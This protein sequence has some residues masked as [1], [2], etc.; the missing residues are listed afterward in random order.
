MDRKLKAFI[1]DLDGVITDT[2]E[3]HYLAWK[4][5]ADELNIPFSR[6]FNEEL[7]GISR[8]DSLEKIIE[9]STQR[10][11]DAEKIELANRKNSYYIEYIETMTPDDILPNMESFI[12]EIKEAGF[13]LGL[14]SASKN[15]FFVLERL[16][17]QQHFHYIVDASKVEKG[18][19]DPEIFL[20]AAKNLDVVPE[21]CIGIEDAISG[22]TAIK[23]AGM[24]AVA[25]GR[26]ESF[27]HAHMVY[28][29]TKE[30]VLD[31]IIQSF[32]GKRY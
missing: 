22:V 26:A 11:E 23:A 19:P 5:L 31:E 4:R 32:H 20:T 28:E 8:M 3:Y 2:A 15:A 13:K 18:K 25:I 12:T 16:G 7:K 10:F 21:Q 6:E 29:S 27:P 14:A 1:F 9:R 30:M 17:L 24:Y